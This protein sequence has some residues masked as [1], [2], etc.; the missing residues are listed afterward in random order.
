MTT[1]RRFLGGL[2]AAG[3]T[4]SL[5]WA[6]AGNACYLTAAQE[7]DGTFALYGLDMDGGLAFRIPLPSRGHAAAAHPKKPEAVAFARRPGTYAIVI[8]CVTGKNLCN[9]TAP[10]GYHFY[11][12]GAFS[13]DGELLFTTENRFETGEGLIGIWQ[14]TKGY[15]R[16]GEFSAGGIGPHDILRCPSTGLLAVANGGIRTHPDSGREKLNLDTMKPNLTVMNTAGEIRDQVALPEDLHQNSLR[17][18]SAGE[19]G[20]IACA[21]QWQGDAFVAPSLVAVYEPGKGLTQLTAP[22]LHRRS[23]SGYAGSVA[24]LK[25][26]QKI[27]ITSPRGGFLQIFDPVEG[28]EGQARRPDISGIATAPGGGLATDGLGGLHRLTETGLSPLRTHD[29][30]FDNHLIAV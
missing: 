17:H 19:N 2:L 21:F 28:F 18:L 20:L 1:R 7:L 12:H 26:P 27:V 9:L 22:E 25:D 30:A 3:A 8:N 24:V 13:A 16:I 23:M 6:D 5:T 29:L 14:S 11:G 4:P 15:R 10:A